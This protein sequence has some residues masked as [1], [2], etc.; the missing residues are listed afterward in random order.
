MTGYSDAF[1]DENDFFLTTY[2]SVGIILAVLFHAG[3]QQ[4]G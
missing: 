2:R 1:T 4:N 3:G